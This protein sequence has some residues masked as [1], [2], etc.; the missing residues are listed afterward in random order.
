MTAAFRVDSGR[1]RPE[2][3]ERFRMNHEDKRNVAVA[4]TVIMV[5]AIV[6]ITVISLDDAPHD[7]AVTLL[8]GFAAPTILL[9][10]N[11]LKSD[12]TGRKV[13][14]ITHSLNGELDRKIEGAVERVMRRHGLCPDTAAGRDAPARDDAA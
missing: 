3:G 4:V 14:A 6:A 11:L 10:A 1:P 5:A 12:E 13:D 2:R 7:N 9:L 8:I